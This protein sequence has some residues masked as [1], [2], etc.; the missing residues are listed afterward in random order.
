[1]RLAIKALADSVLV[2]L[3]GF[4]W[5][6]ENDDYIEAQ[7]F[8]RETKVGPCHISQLPSSKFQLPSSLKFLNTMKTAEFADVEACTVAQ[9]YQ[10]G[11]EL[12][13]SHF[14]ELLTLVFTTCTKIMPASAFQNG[15]SN[16]DS[17]HSCPSP[18]SLTILAESLPPLR[19]R[20]AHS[21]LE[22]G[23]SKTRLH[24]KANLPV[25]V[26]SR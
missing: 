3:L 21:V 8:G 26:P 6:D 23:F 20:Q 5:F 18:R 14:P 15:S 22:F 9:S 2:A 19:Q 17:E 10:E 25:L 13:F 12:E 7:D 4:L 24:L 1:M 11:T 16:A